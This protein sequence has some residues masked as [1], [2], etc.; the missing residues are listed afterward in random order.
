MMNVLIIDDEENARESLANMINMK[1][2]DVE[3]AGF[4]KDVKSGIAAIEKYNPDIILL[5]VNMPDGTGFDLLSKIKSDLYN[6]QVIFI[7]AFEEYAIKAFRF[8]AIDYLLKPVNFDELQQAIEK[9]KTMLKDELKQKIETISYNMNKNV[10]NKK[11]VLKTQDLIHIIKINA[12]I[13]CQSDAG[14][15]TFYT[16]DKKSIMVSQLIKDYEE[17]LSEFGFFRIH[18]THLINLAY[19]QRFDKR[20]GGFAIMADESIIPVSRRKKDLF[21]KTINSI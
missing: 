14:Y 11:I 20:E 8:S 4:G 12:I 5:D 1:C 16:I 15:T 10:E 21:L 9:C 18:Q 13:R 3:I 19:V 7:T 2:K 6:F 17:T